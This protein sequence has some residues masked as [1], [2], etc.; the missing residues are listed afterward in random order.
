M[1]RNRSDSGAPG[2]RGERTLGAGRTPQASRA[3][4]TAN[5]EIPSPA[6]LQ[7]R[8]LLRRPLGSNRSAARIRETPLVVEACCRSRSEIPFASGDLSA[9][10]VGR[11][12]DHLERKL[13]V[14][15][16]LY[17]EGTGVMAMVS[18][19]IPC[20]NQAR[21]LSEAIE[22]VLAQTFG[23]AEVIVVDDGSTDETVTVARRYR[24]VRCLSQRNQGQG[25]ARNEGLKHASGEFV[26]FLD[27]DDR[28][29]PHA[30][31]VGLQCFEAHPDIAFVA[32]RCVYL[33]VDGVRRVTVYEPVVERSHYVRLLLSNYIWM[34]GAVIFRTAAVREAGGF[35]TTVSGAEDYDLYLRIARHQRIWCHDQVIAEYRQHDTSTSRKPMLMMRSTLNVMRGQREWARGNKLAE[36]ALRFGISR[37]QRKYG[38][39]LVTAVRR[40]VRSRDWRLVIPALAA[41]FQ[42]HR[43]GFLSHTRRKMLCLV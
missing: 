20:Y 21:F 36:R 41:L 11:A 34:P 27:S 1:G 16:R 35:K 10:S 9:R 2:G 37:T 3:K 32:G 14:V 4:N 8:H 6:L 7:P 22:S 42:Y 31:E 13:G 15:Q 43:I 38:E 39:Q 25:A 30:F 24:E 33:G 40:Q 28:L 19:V 18:V 29:L 5:D 12:S 26:V 17:A 23:R